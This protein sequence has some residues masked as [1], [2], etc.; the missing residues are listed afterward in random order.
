[1]LYLLLYPLH[2][3]Y[4]GFN[5]LR[6]ETF[7][8]VLA[9]LAALALSL[10]LGPVL[11][12]RF[13]AAHIGQTIR[14]VVPESHRKKEGTPTMGGLMILAAALA[15]TLLLAD[16]YNP[17][18][19]IAI[20]V[21]VAFGALGFSDDYLKL[22]HGKGVGLGGPVKLFWSFAIA[23]AAAIWLFVYL[24]YDTHL[25][26]PFFKNI[27]PNLHRWLYVAFAA[28]VIVGCSHA[29]N[30]TDGLDGLAIG[31]VM[32]VALCYWTFTYVAG[33][34]KFAAY[35]QVPHIDGVG[36]VAIFCAS[37]IAASLGFL[38]YNAY[39]ASMMMGD[40]G[41]LAL[42]AALGTVA[43]L[44]KQELVLLIAGG[45]FVAEAASTIIQRY[46][47]KATHKRVFRMAPLH[48]HFELA[49][50]PETVVVI[51]FWIVSIVCGLVALSTLKLR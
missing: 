9:G 40:V 13:R 41:A 44:A 5:V 4:E 47:F 8:S 28:V 48:H 27:H 7:R 15:A 51:R 26:V 10:A 20:F 17:Y 36:E 34:V 23:L 37:L 45:V 2:T 25:T 6:Y 43:V 39:P 46:Y 18:V 3:H 30:L 32:T 14:D 50:I 49:G 16:L 42:G 21:T 19:W 38:W 11:I 31:P 24:G 29:V 22:R 33:N 1:M 35:L 12:N